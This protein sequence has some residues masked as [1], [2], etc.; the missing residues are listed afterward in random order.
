M[1]IPGPSEVSTSHHEHI[2]VALV[3]QVGELGVE[4]ASCNRDGEKSVFRA[5]ATRARFRKALQVEDLVHKHDNV[6]AMGVMQLR[7][8]VR[9]EEAKVE[10]ERREQRLAPL[11]L[12]N[13][14][15]LI[16]RRR[17]R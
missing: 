2:I 3:T 13:D 15:Q 9:F 17:L 16:D 7:Q 5:Y 10:S 11:L 4:Y 1:A 8:D 6:I 12:C 14:V